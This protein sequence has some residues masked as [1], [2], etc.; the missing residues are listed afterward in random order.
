VFAPLVFDPEYQ[1]EG[2]RIDHDSLAVVGE[3]ESFMTSKTVLAKNCLTIDP[4]SGTCGY[5]E[6]RVAHCKDN[7]HACIGFAAHDVDMTKTLG[8]SGTSFRW[9]HVAERTA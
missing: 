8:T 6:G 5:F 7:G 9:A 3:N 1:G 4:Y 2:V